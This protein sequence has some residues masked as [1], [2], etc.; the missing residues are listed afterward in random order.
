M[1]ECFICHDLNVKSHFTVTLDAVKASSPKCGSCRIIELA[2][3]DAI[4]W[5]EQP[6]ARQTY[7]PEGNIPLELL[8]AL[9]KP[10]ISAELDCQNYKHNAVHFQSDVSSEEF[11]LITTCK[12]V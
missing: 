9:R 7:E 3:E 6:A 11:G 1:A 2:I 8:N 12:C 5:L 10:D 4:F